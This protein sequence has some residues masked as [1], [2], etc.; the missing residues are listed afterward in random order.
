[1]K[2]IQD[3]AWE[4]DPGYF[5]LKQ[6]FK[7]VLAIIVSV[8]LLSGD[9]ILTQLM[10][11]IASGF[12]MQGVVAQTAKAR[13]IHVV[14]FDLAYF[15][16]FALGLSVRG[17]PNLTALALVLMAFGVNYI[18]RFG[19]ENSNAPMSAWILCF[20]ATILPFADSAQ[21]WAHIHGLLIGFAVSAFIILFVFPDHYSRLFI[22]N[23]N[24]FFHT[25]AQGLRD[26]RNHLLIPN[27]EHDLKQ[28]GF[29]TIRSTLIKLVDSNQTLVQSSVFVGKEKEV[30]SILIHQYGLL[31]AYLLMLDAYQA[32]WVNKHPLNRTARLALSQ[33]S[34]QLSQS[35]SAITM[36]DNF[37]VNA[38]HA[39][40]FIPD[41]AKRL[42]RTPLSNRSLIIA[43]LNLKL[44]ADL[45]SQNITGLLRIHDEP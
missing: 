40:C 26:I 21:A 23:S 29:W 6:A 41:M 22:T 45:L 36:Q 7:T 38:E 2:G 37:N 25:L 16:A 13:V 9:T 33:M 17:Y 20:L 39:S 1:M 28:L 18:R 19:F 12:A 4:I 34:K 31:N 35:L 8:G 30:N 32:L 24:R 43:L 15:L 42:G 44:S 14:V 27:L 11:G 3:V 5:N 10:A